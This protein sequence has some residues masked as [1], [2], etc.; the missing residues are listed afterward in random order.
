MKN[1]RLIQNVAATVSTQPGSTSLQK[2]LLQILNDKLH[3]V[4]V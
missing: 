4:N 1:Q 2:A 3:S